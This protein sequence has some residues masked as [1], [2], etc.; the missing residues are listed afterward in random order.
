MSSMMPDDGQPLMR[1]SGLTKYFPANTGWI[2][3]LRGNR[4]HVKAVDGIDLDVEAGRTLAVVG[5]SGSGKS[6]L[7]R[8]MLRLLAPTS[9]E[10]LYRGRDIVAMRGTELRDFRRNVQIVFQDPYSSLNVRMRVGQIIREPLDIYGEG[11]RVERERRVHELLE[12]VGLSI[13]HARAFPS[14]LSGGQRQRVGIAAALALSP[15]LII[16]DEPTSALDVSVQAQTLNLMADLQRD[17]NLTFVFITHDL[18]V[19]QHFSDRVAV[20]YLGK[21]VEEAPNDE[22]FANPQH[23]YSKL[24]FSAIPNPDP[25]KR[26]EWQ[27]P[28]GDP[29]SPL[30]PPPGCAFHPR[31]SQ[32]MPVCPK[33]TPQ[34]GDIKTGHRVSCFLYQTEQQRA[35]KIEQG[36]KNA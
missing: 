21:I 20:M 28:D 33:T 13:A 29:P 11:T 25:T 18:G 3:S 22:L 36:V 10:V 9:G 32:I 30:D 19:V 31:C 12:R 23:P 35:D 8:L 4:R 34:P 16:A 1:V 7:G 15:E 26:A 6:T 24:L 17:F 27:L 5:E 2:E 14:E